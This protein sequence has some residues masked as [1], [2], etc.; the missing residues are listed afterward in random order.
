MVSSGDGWMIFILSDGTGYREMG[1]RRVPGH[2]LAMK[3]T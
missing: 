1:S 3:I 2:F